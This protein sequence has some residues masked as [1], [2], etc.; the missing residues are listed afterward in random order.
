[1]RLFGRCMIELILGWRLSKDWDWRPKPGS[2][3]GNLGSV[4]AWVWCPI[5]VGLFR[6][7][8]GN[9]GSQVGLGLGVRVGSGVS[10]GV[11]VRVWFSG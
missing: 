10:F 11:R 5:Q 7:P 6:G 9:G 4:P 8:L 2:R 1:M 3:S